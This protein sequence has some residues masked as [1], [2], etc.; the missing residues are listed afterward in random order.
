MLNLGQ[1]VGQIDTSLDQIDWIN[2]DGVNQAMINDHVRNQFFDS[3]LHEVKGRH[4]VDIGF[5]TGLLTILALKHGASHVTAFESDSNRFL[6]GQS[7]IDHLGLGNRVSLCHQ[8]YCHS[9]PID[10]E[11]V[12]FSETVNGNL[13]QE[14]LWNS[15]PRQP[16]T[17]F[18]PQQY[19][20]EF[21]A[22][23]VPDAFV[24]GLDQPESHLTPFNPGVDLDCDF[25]HTINSYMSRALALD[26]HS[27]NSVT[28]CP[29]LWQFDDQVNTAWGWI[30]HMRCFNPRSKPRAWYTVD[31]TQC[32]LRVSGQEPS[33]IDFD[34]TKHCMTLSLPQAQAGAVLVI[35]RAVLTHHE[36]NLYLDQG[37]W[38]PMRGAVI[39]NRTQKQL[40]VCHDF[41][42]GLLE[43]QLR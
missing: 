16:G 3:I 12:V 31:A 13:W 2:H 41:T 36:H 42:N 21:Y 23:P 14:G 1:R 26:G 37:H 32:T 25:V 27:T 5:G 11:C 24:A 20:V 15:L 17:R 29:E 39:V 28:E 30:P 43:Y 18:L 38:G 4:C 33:T 22:T 35:P 34:Q 7:I 19:S 9:T 40:E 10:P 6:L 8:R